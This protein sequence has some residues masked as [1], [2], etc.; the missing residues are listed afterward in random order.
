[1]SRRNIL[2]CA[3]LIFMTTCNS[4]AFATQPPPYAS[5]VA[6]NENNISGIGGGAN[7]NFSTL[8]V[9]DVINMTPWDIS[10]GSGANKP[11]FPGN[12]GIAGAPYSAWLGQW[13]AGFHKPSS[14]TS[15]FGGNF[16]YHSIQIALNN[17]NNVWVLANSVPGYAKPLYYDTIPIVVNSNSF[18]QNSNTANLTFAVTSAQSFTGIAQN[19]TS[20]PATAL[21]IGDGNNNYGWE[22]YNISGVYGVGGIPYIST[23][24][25]LTVLGLGNNANVWKPITNNLGG[26]VANTGVVAKG[27][28][29][30]PIVQSPN[31][32][33][34]AGLVYPNFSAVAGDKGNFDLVVILQAG[35]Y[36][37]MQLLFLAVPNS[38]DAFL[39]GSTA[40]RD[41]HN[42]NLINARIKTNPFR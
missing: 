14:S 6:Y 12:P 34:V 2:L 29:G 33:T 39:A 41:R 37:D 23:T 19:Q 22:N 42:S 25:F 4:I 35:G 13:L 18:T 1:M 8:G 24:H 27:Y 10:L 9:L 20:F 38:N 40:G 7:P 5:I 16:A 28:T 31:L 30:S 21:S 26:V 17:L 3:L 36:A 15:N 32:L 11:L